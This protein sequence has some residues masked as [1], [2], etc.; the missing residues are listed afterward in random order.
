MH[1]VNLAIKICLIYLVLVTVSEGSELSIPNTFEDGQVTSAAEMNANFKAVETAIN[2]ID[3]RVNDIT[4]SS[5][6]TFLG[7]SSE[8]ITGGQGFFSMQRMCMTSFTD[9]KMC[10]TEDIFNSKITDSALA[11]ADDGYAWILTRDVN[12]IYSIN[13]FRDCESWNSNSN[14]RTGSAISMQGSIFE[15]SCN[16]SAQIA[17]CK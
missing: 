1:T 17:C 5:T 10:H 8:K 11:S 15:L 7:F 2:N 14:A 9:S 6:R 4:K 13:E 3:T 16:S 12:G